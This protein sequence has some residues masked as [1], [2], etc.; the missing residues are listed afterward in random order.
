MAIKV[1]LVHN[2]SEKSYQVWAI[3]STRK[4]TIERP[5]R[6]TNQSSQIQCW[7]D[8]LKL[9]ASFEQDIECKDE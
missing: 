1:Q 9:A 7:D 6:Y 5:F 4:Y 3:S 8:A 2:V